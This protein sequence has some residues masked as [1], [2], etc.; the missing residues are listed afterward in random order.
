MSRE[1]NSEGAGRLQLGHNA[2]DHQ[3][4]TS[5]LVPFQFVNHVLERGET[6]TVV[7]TLLEMRSGARPLLW[8]H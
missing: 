6:V 5:S 7:R 1:A 2:R 4:S 3:P 8:K